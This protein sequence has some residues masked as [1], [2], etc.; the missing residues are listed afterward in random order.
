MISIPLNNDK[1]L[2]FRIKTKMVN[3]KNI[4]LLINYLTIIKYKYIYLY[5]YLYLFPF[6][7]IYHLKKKKNIYCLHIKIKIK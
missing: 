4:I 3:I 1:V 6:L 2:I 7:N 5:L